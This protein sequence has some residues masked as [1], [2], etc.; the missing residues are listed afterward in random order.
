MF[1]PMPDPRPPSTAPAAGLRRVLGPVTGAAIVAGTV[2]G[3]GVFIK[4]AAMAQAVGDSGL[5]LLA[6]IVAGVLSLAGALTYAELGTRLPHAG[7]E[8]VYLREA[9]GRPAAFLF[10]WM[11]FWVA[12]PGSVAVFAV[13]AAKFTATTGPLAEM[14]GG[15]TALALI[16]IALFTATNCMAV[17]L[18]ARVQTLMTALK[19]LI[20]VGLGVALFVLGGDT[21]SAPPVPPAAPPRAFDLSTFGTA[22][23]AALWAFDGWN[24]LAMVGGEIRDPR[25]NIPRAL[26]FGMAVVAGL[27]LFANFAYFHV[28]GTDEVA[29]SYSSANQN[30]L[31]VATKALLTSLGPTSSWAT[32]AVAIV[33]GLLVISALGAMNGS[34]MTGAR[35]PYAMARDRLV[36]AALGRVSRHG[37]S[38]VAAVVAQGIVASIL[39]VSGTFDQLTDAVV[40]ASW[41][42]YA[43]CTGAVFRLRRRFPTEPGTFLTPLYPVLPIVFIAVAGLLLV[44]TIMTAPELSALGLGVIALGVPVYLVIRRYVPTAPASDALPPSSDA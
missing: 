27:Y 36:P 2:I 37:G 4:P 22:V 24:N 43:M 25:R 9:Y 41:V 31:P 13:A 12:S 5:V 14:P 21:P 19:V 6:W 16:F 44:N 34:I 39:A 18:G 17:T 20:I 28:L 32:S 7:G 1:P 38:P 23:I 33:S 10:G 8:Y 40:F 11:R 15:Q 3:T 29:A 35:V 26:I 30:A 42:F